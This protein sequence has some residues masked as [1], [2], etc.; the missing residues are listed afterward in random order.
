MYSSHKTKQKE[1]RFHHIS[2][3]TNAQPL[4]SISWSILLFSPVAEST[5]STTDIRAETMFP[6]ANLRT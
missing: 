1:Y 4:K 5:F 2:K 6:Q 3:T